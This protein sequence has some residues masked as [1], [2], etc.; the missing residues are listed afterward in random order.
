MSRKPINLD[1]LKNKRIPKD[2]GLP[3]LKSGK[4]LK[5]RRK[6][7][8]WYINII[9][10]FV[11][12]PVDKDKD[13]AELH[14]ILPK[15]MGGKNNSENLIYLPIRYH[16]TCHILLHRIY[17]DLP[18]L[19]FAVHAIFNVAYKDNATYEG[20]RQARREIIQKHY[21]TK[22]IAKIRSE[23]V[24]ASRTEEAKAIHR[25]PR[26][27]ETKEKLRKANLGKKHTPE[28]REKMSESRRG[29]KSWIYGKHLSEETKAKLSKAN[30]GKKR[31]PD[32]VKRSADGIRGEKNWTFGK[33]LP[34][35][36]REKISK[37]VSDR[38]K[39]NPDIFGKARTKVIDP[40]GREFNS[41]KE[42]A[43]FWG[44]NQSTLGSK[45][46]R[47]IDKEGWQYFTSGRKATKRKKKY[48]EEA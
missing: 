47:N 28:S 3:K 46:S 39:E 5:N 31:D 42:A 38:W 9:D 13:V 44:I 25:K 48:N 29:E 26:S 16:I 17:P 11:L 37:S 23:F 7:R 33:H 32:A 40:N 2:Y 41:I 4:N 34:K 15:C 36:M 45:L 22:E 35:E 18:G 43:A 1:D 10:K 24:K 12:N 20:E 8:R 27:E 14:H 6:Y 19:A 30:K 21:S